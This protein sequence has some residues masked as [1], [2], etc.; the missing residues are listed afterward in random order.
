MNTTRNILVSG[1]AGTGKTRLVV[2]SLQHLSSQGV[3]V[4]TTAMTGC[5]AKQIHGRTVHHYLGLGCV[6]ESASRSEIFARV[7][8]NRN[9]C[10]RIL[11]LDLLIVDE[12]SMMSSFFFDLM[13]ETLK[14][15]RQN[16]LPFG[17]VR[18][19]LVGDF[20]NYPLLLRLTITLLSNLADGCLKL[21][22]GQRVNLSFT[23]YERI[24]GR[25]I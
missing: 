1:L 19:I 13:N 25:G 5:A 4:G 12:V 23:V 11:K 18:L 20:S 3:T 6:D 17:G 9:A 14:L 10:R 24:L 2:D 22:H 7:C 16:T 21:S 15:I 8:S